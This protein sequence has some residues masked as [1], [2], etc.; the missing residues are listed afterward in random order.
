ME[1]PMHRQELLGYLDEMADEK[2]IRHSL[3]V[4]QSAVELAKIHGVDEKKA[5]T[6]ALL[7]DIYRS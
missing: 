3:G 5:S 4:E 2:R 1:G 6:A 7:H